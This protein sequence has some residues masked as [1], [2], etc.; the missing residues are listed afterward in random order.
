MKKFTMKP[1]PKNAEYFLG[2][3]FLSHP[4]ESQALNSIIN[5]YRAVAEA[6]KAVLLPGILGGIDH[7][8]EVKAWKE[9]LAALESEE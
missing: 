4:D 9:A 7:W 5:K 2:R 6:A 8:P 1:L 3:I